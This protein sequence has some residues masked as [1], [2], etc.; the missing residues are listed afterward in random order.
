MPRPKPATT[1]FTYEEEQK[2]LQ[3]SIER[4]INTSVGIIEG[5]PV[6]EVESAGINLEDWRDLKWLTVKL[7]N[8][9]RDRVFVARSEQQ[10]NKD[11]NDGA[12]KNE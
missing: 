2:L 7:W 1:E 8:A 10:F 3:N 6:K 5:I 11:M 4:V 9:A 12:P